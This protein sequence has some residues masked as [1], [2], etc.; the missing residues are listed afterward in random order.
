MTVL[1]RPLV[2][3][4]AFAVAGIGVAQDNPSGLPD[5]GSSAGEIL[6]PAQE[7]M[8]GEMTLRELRRYGLL[9]EDPLIEAYFQNLGFRLV[10][11][12]ER[13]QHPFTF[14][15]VGSRDINAFATLGGY[16][17]MN[18]GLI[19]TAESEDEVAAVLAH[20]ISHVTQR[21]VLRG[22]ERAQKDSIPIAL[23][24]IGALIAASQTGVSDDAVQAAVVGGVG[25]MQQRQINYTRSNEH[26][27]D[28]IGVH[29]LARAG[30]DPVAM[31]GFFA[32]MERATR[33][34]QGGWQA[35][36]YLRTHPVSTTRISEAKDRA[37]RILREQGAGRSCVLDAQGNEQECRASEPASRAVGEPGPLHPLLPVSL[38]GGLDR[39]A[40][41]GDS[42]LFDLA[43]E[44][45]RVLSAESPSAAV[46]EYQK[47]RNSEPE[48][49]RDAQ[50]YGLAISQMHLGKTSEAEQTLSELAARRPGQHWIELALAE[51]AQ[52]AGH[53]AVAAQR[54]SDLLA[55]FPSNRAIILSYA[56]SLSE[57]G[58]TEAGRKAQD[59][60]RPILAEGADDAIFQ[61]R[62][63][64]ASELAGD[65]I[66]AGEAYAEA[67]YLGGRPEDALNQLERLKQR[68]DL[69][70]YQRARIDARIAAIT[71]TVLEWRERGL[72]PS[73]QA[74]QHRATVRPGLTLSVGRTDPEPH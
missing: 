41:Q 70:Y 42:G 19:L 32:R 24:M 38:A 26:E 14:F 8:Y 64:R 59:A 16:V 65:V 56:R 36:E 15:V 47:L 73:D 29:T 11:R 10:A 7:R 37:Q 54:Y 27:A 60:L 1:L 23:A 72:R 12:S 4:L 67:A 50:H 45:L 61:Q 46:A 18:A 57:Q 58:T 43:R 5:I 35:P 22:A 55:A 63:A 9:L 49:F 33:G 69:N 51:N 31:A 66:R 21:H 25:L 71:P 28:R 20:E 13:P 53:H 30:Y 2:L 62:F 39:A 52:R 17:G 34:N 74:G 48:L 44:R 68:D 6:S 40:P 3:C